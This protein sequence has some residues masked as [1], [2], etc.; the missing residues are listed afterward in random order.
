MRF[1]LIGVVL[2][3]FALLGCGSGK[4]TNP[5]APPEPVKGAAPGYGPPGK[6]PLGP[7]P[8]YGEKK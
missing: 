8:G 4:P 5:G 7:P 2:L 3:S 1:L 6:T